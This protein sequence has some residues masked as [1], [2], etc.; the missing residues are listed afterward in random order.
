ME[1]VTGNYFDNYRSSNCIHRQLVSGFLCAAMSLVLRAEPKSAIE[2]GAGPGDLAARLFMN[3][4]APTLDY[5]GT[6]IR[7]LQVATAK[8]RYPQFSF[9]CASAYELPTPNGSYELGVA[10]EPMWQMLNCGRGK[11]LSSFGNT[12]GHA[13]N[14]TRRKIRQ[15]ISPHFE[16]VLERRP[17]PWTMFLVRVR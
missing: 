6:D 12:P 8:A 14:F 11:Y 16:I 4:E 15:L 17:F 13:Q 5:L 10:W 1:L 9:R 2:I 3:A 7:E